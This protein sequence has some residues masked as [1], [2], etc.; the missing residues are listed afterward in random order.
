V[1][2]ISEKLTSER[3]DQVSH[4]GE[5]VWHVGTSIACEARY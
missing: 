1:V 3:E 4:K 5:T 2:R